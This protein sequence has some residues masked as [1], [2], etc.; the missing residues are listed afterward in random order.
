MG[1]GTKTCRKINFWNSCFQ[2]QCLSASMLKEG[3]TKGASIISARNSTVTF[4]HF[5]HSV[6]VKVF[7]KE[8]IE[9]HKNASFH[10]V[11]SICIVCVN[12]CFRCQQNARMKSAKNVFSSFHLILLSKQTINQLCIAML[13]KM[14]LSPRSQIKDETRNYCVVNW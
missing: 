14:V 4:H 1:S 11:A 13:S 6:V 9:K 2:A 3:A 12:A 10:L 7:G 8:R 5:T